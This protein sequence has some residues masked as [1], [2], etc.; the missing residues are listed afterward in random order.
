MGRESGS[1]W[2]LSP[3]LNNICS[4]ISLVKELPYLIDL[5]KTPQRINVTVKL[6]IKLAIVN[7]KLNQ[8]QP[9]EKTQMCMYT[10]SWE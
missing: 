1:G 10:Y 3:Q 9:K 7:K 2:Q 4:S 6:N 5:W 8:Y